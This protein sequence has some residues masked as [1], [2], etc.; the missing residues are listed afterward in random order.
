[1]SKVRMSGTPISRARYAEPVTPPEG[2]ER[3]I[4]IGLSATACVLIAPPSERTMESRPPN[5]FS[6][7]EVSKFRM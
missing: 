6:P 3:A 1:M 4:W 7:I 5:R 2:P